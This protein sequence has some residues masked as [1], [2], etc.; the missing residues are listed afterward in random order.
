MLGFRTFAAF[1]LISAAVPLGCGGT[2]QSDAGTGDA[3]DGTRDA[4]GGANVS[5][6]AGGAGTGG[7]SSGGSVSSPA[8]GG[9]PYTSSCGGCS[10]PA[11]CGT[12]EVDDPCACGC[13]NVGEIE[14]VGEGVVFRCTEEGCLA[15]E[16][17]ICTNSDPTGTTGP[18]IAGCPCAVAI[19]DYCCDSLDSGL[20]YSCST[21]GTW[22]GPF[23]VP[24][25]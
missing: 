1:A 9:Q 25:G 20:G 22:S 6:G 4:G 8:T 21:D 2:T 16:L 5:G 23:S 13:R 15:I 24:G 14:R 12:A 19:G 7:V 17:A 3:I 11:V 10:A 18:V